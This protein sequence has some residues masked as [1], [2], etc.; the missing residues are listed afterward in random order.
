MKLQEDDPLLQVLQHIKKSKE[1]SNSTL[2]FT[3]NYTNFKTHR[4]PR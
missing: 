4:L 3:H 1:F 2:D